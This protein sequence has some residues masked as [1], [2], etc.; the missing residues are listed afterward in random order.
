M[1]LGAFIAQ[2]MAGS[3]VDQAPACLLGPLGLRISEALNIDIDDL[4]I[5]RGHRTA[6]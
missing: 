2:G 3:V 1:E 5:E 6:R 4:G